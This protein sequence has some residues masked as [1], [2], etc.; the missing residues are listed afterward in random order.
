[1]TVQI[2]GSIAFDTIMVFEGRFKDHILPEQTHMLNVAFLAPQMRQEYGGC[3]AN[4]AFTLR[5]LGQE[6][7]LL[8]AIGRDGGDYLER[9]S[10][11]GI[12]TSRVL[13][14]EDCYSAQAFITTDLDDNQ[15][16]AFHPGA[17]N[18]AGE[19]GLGDAQASLG[20]VSP[21]GRED[22]STRTRVLRTT[23]PIYFRSG[24]GHAHLRPGGSRGI[25]QPG[26]L[27]GR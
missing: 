15:I 2:S 7:G 22:D 27:G 19:I 14:A 24:P 21:N 20:I 1:M 12:D 11:L 3:A 13:S 26:D 16:T 9:L 23:R 6:C 10:G 4:I 17:M 18:R 8:G 5:A 25:C